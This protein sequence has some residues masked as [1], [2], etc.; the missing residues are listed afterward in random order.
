MKTVEVLL[1]ENLDPIGRCG[2]VV[3]VKSGFARNYLL[4]N[5]LAVA[6]TPDNKKAMER[7]RLR[8]DAE[9]A[10]RVAEIETRIMVISSE[11]LT[12][13]QK[14]DENG[15]LYGSVS[16]AT[17]VELL[18][19]AGKAIDEKDVRIETPIKVVGTHKVRIHV[20]GERYAEIEIAVEREGGMPAPP[21]APEADDAAAPEPTA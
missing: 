21:P 6:A 14:A 5:R 10:E 9:E 18:G 1:R 16:P 7:R 15:H 11:R 8:L 2:D 3:R 20:H 13:V 17:V 19:A 12:T 4:P